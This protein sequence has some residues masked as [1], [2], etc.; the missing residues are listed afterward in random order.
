M[1]MSKLPPIAKS[2]KK[3]AVGAA[4]TVID[5]SSRYCMLK[6]LSGNLYVTGTEDTAV[7]ADSFKITPDMVFEFT[8][9]L[10]LISDAT[11]ADVRVL[12]YDNI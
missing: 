10:R 11:G 12:F 6:V 2:A 7:T 8:G 3:Y 9:T 1:Y 4:A 5:T